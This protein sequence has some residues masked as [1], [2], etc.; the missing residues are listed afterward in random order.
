MSQHNLPGRSRSR[1]LL[2]LSGTV[3]LGYD[4]EGYKLFTVRETA[5]NWAR[6]RGGRF[7]ARLDV[8]SSVFTIESI[9]KVTVSL[10]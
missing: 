8:P 2:D 10:S 5:I 6:E 1:D 7:V 3:W 9:E 4:H